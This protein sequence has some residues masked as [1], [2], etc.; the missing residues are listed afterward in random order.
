MGIIDVLVG[1]NLLRE[2]LD[3][4]EVALVAIIDADKEGFLRSEQAL[5]QT[6]GRAARNRN[7]KVLMYA[8][9]LTKSMK[10]AINETDR[11]RKIQQAHN[12]KYCILPTSI[13]K[14]TDA[15][16]AQT[17]VADNASRSKNFHQLVDNMVAEITVSAQNLSVLE[18]N[19][20]IR[21]LRKKMEYAAKDMDFMA[22][23]HFR[24]EMFRLEKLKAAKEK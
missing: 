13:L 8:D 6:I 16:L 9:R 2:G 3:L 14:S 10:A 4:P 19:N 18:L 24:D 22:A 11:R 5:I 17:K 15:I 20:R 1:V 23:A 12:E 7:G 21:E